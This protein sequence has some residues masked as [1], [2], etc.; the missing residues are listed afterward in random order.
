MPAKS[1]AALV[2]V[3]QAHRRQVHHQVTKIAIPDHEHIQ[4]LF[5][6]TWPR[7]ESW[8]IGDRLQIFPQGTHSG[9]ICSRAALLGL[10]ALTL[11]EG[12]LTAADIVAQ[13]HRVSQRT[14]KSCGWVVVCRHLGLLHSHMASFAAPRPDRLPTGRCGRLT[15]CSSILAL[16][17]DTVSM[18]LG[19]EPCTAAAPVLRALASSNT[20]HVSENNMGTSSISLLALPVGPARNMTD[21]AAQLTELELSDESRTP[22]RSLTASVIEELTK[23]YWPCL[24]HLYLMRLVPSLDVISHLVHG[25][26]P[27]LSML[28]IA[29]AA[30]QA[31][32]LQMLAQ[33]PW[34]HLR[35][36]CLTANLQDAAVSE[37]FL[38]GSEAHDQQLLR[39]VQLQAQPGYIIIRGPSSA[40]AY[41]EGRAYIQLPKC[42]AQWL[43][44]SIH[45]WQ[46]HGC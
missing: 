40:R 34:M 35:H 29:G 25:R 1:L 46:V 12:P 28:E 30:L 6:G 31:P 38:T 27:K 24:E 2:A 42:F 45:L 23:I 22:E 14:L 4:T 44:L 17:D 18:S 9:Y 20:P 11:S 21:W 37:Q 32:A 36:L 8:Q 15:P 13:L 10:E 39:H 16:L 41:S 7:L 3:N 26:W 43:A 19:S 5:R 33:A